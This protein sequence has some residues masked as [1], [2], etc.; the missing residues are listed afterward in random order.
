M[1]GGTFWEQLGASLTG[2]T[3]TEL[4]QQALNIQQ[5]LAKDTLAAE[6]EAQKLKYN[7]ELSKQRTIQIALVGIPIIIIVGVFIYIKFIK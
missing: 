7:P 6:I 1:A 5:Q 4:S 3:K 2:Q